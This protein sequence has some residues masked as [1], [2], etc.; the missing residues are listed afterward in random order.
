VSW[1]DVRD[2]HRNEERRKAWRAVSRVEVFG[3]VHEGLETSD[4][5]TP[6]D[7]RPIRVKVAG[8][9][10][11]A[12]VLE[13]HFR[14]HNGVLREQVHFARV[15][16]VNPLA[17]IEVLDLAR[18]LRLEVGGVKARDGGSAAFALDQIGP[19]R[20]HVIAKRRQRP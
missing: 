4:A 3:F 10:R 6:N 1:S 7:T 2:H 18:K 15:T 11:E 13:C 8:L 9:D 12:G 14:R 20:L 16:T 19:K 5:R 17:G